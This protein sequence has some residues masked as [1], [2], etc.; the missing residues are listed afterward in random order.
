V[1]VCPYTPNVGRLPDTSAALDRMAA[2]VVEVLLPEVRAK[3]PCDPSAARTGIDG[4]SLGGFVGLEL[5][6]RR[7]HAFGAWG[8]VQAALRASSAGRSAERIAE[9]LR[10]AGPRRLHVETSLS[11]PFHDANVALSHEL[12]RRNVAHE[13][14]VLPGPH[15]QPWLRDAGT[16]EMLLWHDRALSGG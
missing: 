11:D 3:T 4:C 13:L 10:A 12:E 9:A 15:D 6:L 7:P 16:L 14:R 2:W 8:G 5:F 1:Y